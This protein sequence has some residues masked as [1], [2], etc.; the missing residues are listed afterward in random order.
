MNEQEIK[1]LKD[2][3]VARKIFKSFCRNTKAITGLDFK[4][5]G[6]A[7]TLKLGAISEPFF[8]SRTPEGFS[9]WG[10]VNDE[11]EAIVMKERSTLTEC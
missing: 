9:F 6:E 3:L 1:Q 10:I 2:F 11:W 5:N 4:A 8:W 7:T